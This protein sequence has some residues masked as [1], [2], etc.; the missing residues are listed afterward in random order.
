MA[1]GTR[2]TRLRRCRTGGGGLRAG[3]QY[4]ITRNGR[5]FRGAPIDVLSPAEAVA[6]ISAE[7]G[8]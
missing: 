3:E 7:P 8:A 4:L 1:P 5:D 2:A 6:V